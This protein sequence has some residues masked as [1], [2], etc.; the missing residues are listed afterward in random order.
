MTSPAVSASSEPDERREASAEGDQVAL[1]LGGEIGLPLGVQADPV[2]AVRLRQQQRGVGRAQHAVAV[3]GRLGE[4]GDADRHRHVD[5]IVADVDGRDRGADALRERPRLL[6]IGARQDH[7][8]LLAAVAR[9]V[10]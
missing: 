7:R 8:E 1:E 10:V 3:Y 4:G 9:Q 2:A 6:Q 5:R